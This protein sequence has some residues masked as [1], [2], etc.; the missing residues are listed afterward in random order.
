[1]PAKLQAKSK[2]SGLQQM[3]LLQQL[4]T[5]LHFLQSVRNYEF[6]EG[7]KWNIGVA[8]LNLKDTPIANP[9]AE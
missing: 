2:W 7:G 4:N 5:S 9:Y 8:P 3:F 1:M 6:L